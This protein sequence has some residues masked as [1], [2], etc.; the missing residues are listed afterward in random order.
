MKKKKKVLLHSAKNDGDGCAAP[1]LTTNDEKVFFFPPQWRCPPTSWLFQR[2][3]DSAGVVASP[4]QAGRSKLASSLTFPDASHLTQSSTQTWLA[5]G[6]VRGRGARPQETQVRGCRCFSIA[7]PP[8]K[9]RNRKEDSFSAEC[10]SATCN[11]GRKDC[12]NDALELC[13]NYAKWPNQLLFPSSA[14]C[15]C[16]WM[17]CPIPPPFFCL[18]LSF[19]GSRCRGCD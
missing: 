10:L 15:A 14:W 12:S 19:V 16:L 6:F 2:W 18:F 4:N 7:P 11:L 5:Q 1:F 9:D 13:T 17:H 3:T 8:R